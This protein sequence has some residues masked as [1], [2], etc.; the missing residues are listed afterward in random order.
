M[1]IAENDN[2]LIYE[3][4]SIYHSNSLNCGVKAVFSQRNIKP[5]IKYLPVNPSTP[6][7]NNFSLCNTIMQPIIKIQGSLEPPKNNYNNANPNNKKMATNE[8]SN[9]FFQKD[10]R[11]KTES[12]LEKNINDEKLLSRLII[13]TKKKTSYN[14]LIIKKSNFEKNPFFLGRTFNSKKRDLNNDFKDKDNEKNSDSDGKS[15]FK[16][17][18]SRSVY[19]EKNRKNNHK[20]DDDKSD[21]VLKKRKN[22]SI[23]KKEFLN[24]KIENKKEKE[25]INKEKLLKKK[26][27]ASKTSKKENEKNKY[28]EEGLKIKKEK[29]KL[30]RNERC[31]SYFNNKYTTKFYN[32]ETISKKLK[33]EA[34]KIDNNKNYKNENNENENFED[35]KSEKKPKKKFKFN[36]LK[37][38]KIETNINKTKAIKTLKEEIKEII[39][40]KDSKFKLSNRELNHLKENFKI[41]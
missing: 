34:N 20:E 12:S 38:Q 17:G 15:F 19:S 40:E 37:T 41:K 2:S 25:K 13:E 5:I 18:P 6:H 29:S 4:P 9:S 26:N 28:K 36:R 11:D 21:N 16:K 1:I 33:N 3:E 31:K 10:T 35:K 22:L 7:N 8:K 39:K 23:I 30:D 24:L 14:N 27:I 32:F